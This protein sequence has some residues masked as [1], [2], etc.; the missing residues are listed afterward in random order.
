MILVESFEHQ[1]PSPDLSP[2][3][4]QSFF[5]L[6]YMLLIINMLSHK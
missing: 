2:G 4:N 5:N 1:Y 3:L 6:F